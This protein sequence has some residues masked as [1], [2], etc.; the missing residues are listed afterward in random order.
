MV[1]GTVGLWGVS[2]NMD[3]KRCDSVAARFGED[4]ALYC[5]NELNVFPVLMKPPNPVAIKHSQ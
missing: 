3:W 2:M 4:P 5:D 1:A